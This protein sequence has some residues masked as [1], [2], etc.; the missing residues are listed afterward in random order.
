MRNLFGPRL[1]EQTRRCQFLPIDTN[2]DAKW[3]GTDTRPRYLA[4]LGTQPPDWPY[5]TQPVTYTVNRE[6]YRCAEFD[7]IDWSQ[8]LVVFGC[9][10]VFGIGVTDQDTMPAQLSMITGLPVI[11]MGQAASSIEFNLAN[12]V[13]LSH[14]CPRPRA[15]IHLWTGLDRSVYYGSRS[16]EFLGSWSS[17]DYFTAR[18]Q[19]ACHSEMQA[20][21]AKLTTESLWRDTLLWQGSY[22]KETAE[23]LGIPDCHRHDDNAR[24]LLHP[25]VK[26][27]G[28]VAHQIASDLALI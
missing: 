23:L 26:S 5:R 11:N 20:L 21:I 18:S 7:Q 4:N 19:R 10:M 2:I 16:L 17:S 25:G 13:I 15:V 14:I 12:S 3:A 24:D 22:F 8:S 28:R 1:F 6:G 27:H 9:S